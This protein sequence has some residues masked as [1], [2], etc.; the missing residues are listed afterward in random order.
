MHAKHSQKA[1]PF[2][3][4][5][6][7]MDLPFHNRLTYN[8]VHR[9]IGSRIP[10]LRRSAGSHRHHHCRELL[11]FQDFDLPDARLRSVRTAAHAGNM[12][13]SPSTIGNG[14][15]SP[16]VL[17]QSGGNYGRWT[18]Y[19]ASTVLYEHVHNVRPHL[20]FVCAQSCGCESAR[21]C[22]AICVR[23]LTEAASTPSF[24]DVHD[25]P[26]RVRSPCKS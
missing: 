11:V 7:K 26:F 22:C 10:C 14:P 5:R 24:H 23:P 2:S 13:F 6:L 12:D 9:R 25:F 3:V 19:N 18:F 8:S 21:V 4:A 15:Y 17:V 1:G 20:A 16:R